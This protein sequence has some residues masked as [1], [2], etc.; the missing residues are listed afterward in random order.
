MQSPSA[1]SHSTRA[2]AIGPAALLLAFQIALGA[3]CTERP[4]P[5]LLLVVSDTLRAD[6]LSCQGGHARTPNLCAL[7]DHGVLFE[8]AYSNSSWT[9]P[10]A[11]SIFTGNH[12]SEYDRE[13]EA[14]SD[15][16]LQRHFLYVDDEELLCAEALRD[17][18]YETAAFLENAV[19]ARSNALQGFET[20]QTGDQL[21]GVDAGAA[22]RIRRELGIDVS[23]ERQRRLVPVLG[24]LL[25][26]GSRPFFVMHWLMDPHSLYEPEPARMAALDLDPERLPRPPEFYTRLGSHHRPKENLYGLRR[27]GADLTIDERVALKRLYLA[28]VESVDERLG[29]IL[30]ALER[31]GLRD[32]TLIVFTSDHG[33]GFGE[34]GSYLHGSAF[35]GELVHV[36]L[37][38]AGPG[39]AAGRRVSEPVSLVDLMPTVREFL[40][41]DCLRADVRGRS[42][43]PL[44]EGRVEQ[45][46]RTHYLVNAAPGHAGDALIQGRYKL[47][48]RPKE[49]AEL[50]DLESD[51]GEKRSL[52]EELPEVTDT[53]MAE[54]VRLRKDNARRRAEN[55]RLG[56]K[57][58]L[59]EVGDETLEQLRAIG[60]VD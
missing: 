7:A 53:L 13:R 20:L 41:V 50:Y 60:Y 43:R 52:V 33:E 38:I 46:D 28:E 58:R 48:W 34:H 5:N 9:L 40:R 11:V 49:P 19:P 29:T 54:L 59:D 26:A 25:D 10:A 37:I 6:A 55:L 8:R 21:D 24:R 56:D 4:P 51:P 42:L 57:D 44:L 2:R 3:G 31:R 15:D 14:T 12:A 39:I 23:D 17:R 45:A 22:D 36:P 16:P 27:F 47:I 18:G 30:A 32:D 35:H 1:S